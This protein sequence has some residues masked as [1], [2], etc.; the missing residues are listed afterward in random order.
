MNKSQISHEEMEAIHPYIPATYEQ[1]RQGRISRREFLR[2]VTL[3]GMSAGTAML[4][5]AC[6]GGAAET[7]AP[8][9]EEDAPKHNLPPQTTPFFG[10]ETELAGIATNLADPLAAC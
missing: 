4:L 7:E 1:L 6:G 2:T 8:V 9:A 10:R 3:L 5:A